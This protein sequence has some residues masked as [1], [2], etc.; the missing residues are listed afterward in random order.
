MPRGVKG[1]PSSKEVSAPKRQRKNLPE[2]EDVK[3]ETLTLK[4]SRPGGGIFS[5]SSSWY[6]Y[7]PALG[8]LNNTVTP[9]GNNKYYN[10]MIY[11]LFLHSVK[12]QT[13][14]GGASVESAASVAIRRNSGTANVI[15]VV[16][17]NYLARYQQSTGGSMGEVTKIVD[18][19][20]PFNYLEFNI[21]GAQYFF[22]IEFD[23][24]P[25]NPYQWLS[26]IFDEYDVNF[27]SYFP[28]WRLVDPW[29]YNLPVPE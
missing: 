29:D 21:S 10:G 14:V 13:N 15:D 25:L 7:T 16:N 5:T 17:K 11:T 18:R 6:T 1:T 27:N 20:V 19:F 12:F 23:W 2:E 9:F 3:M 28:Q 26:I 4:K 24:R 8:I 22:T